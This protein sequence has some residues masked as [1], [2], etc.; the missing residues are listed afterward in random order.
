MTHYL[1]WSDSENLVYLPTQSDTL[2]EPIYSVRRGV[3]ADV[4]ITELTPTDMAW[5]TRM[6]ELLCISHNKIILL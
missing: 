4:K 1:K 2:S 3:R 5:L 6:A